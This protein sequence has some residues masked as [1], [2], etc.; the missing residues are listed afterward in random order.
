MSRIDADVP[1]APSSGRGDRGE[2][3]GLDKVAN[4]R[5]ETNK[6]KDEAPARLEVMPR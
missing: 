1:L 5:S 6:E 3:S 2:G 4:L